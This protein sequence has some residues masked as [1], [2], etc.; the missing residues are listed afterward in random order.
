MVRKDLFQSQLQATVRIKENTDECKSGIKLEGHRQDLHYTHE[1]VCALLRCRGAHVWL[2]LLL[3]RH[4]QVR[5]ESTNCHKSWLVVVKGWLFFFYRFVLFFISNISKA[6]QQYLTRPSTK[7]TITFQLK[8]FIQHGYKHFLENNVRE[9][10]I[11]DLLINLLAG[12]TK[13]HW[14][15]WCDWCD[16]LAAWIEKDGRKSMNWFIRLHCVA[17]FVRNSTTQAAVQV[18]MQTTQTAASFTFQCRVEPHLQF[19]TS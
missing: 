11:K 14:F 5:M 17:V 18:C 16:Y 9:N 13:K 10:I 4:G 12:E 2:L 7:S 3:L 15:K 1:R 19:H 8:R 6:H